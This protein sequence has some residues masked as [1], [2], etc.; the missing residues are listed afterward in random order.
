M[1]VIDS[2][3]TSSGD[4]SVPRYYSNLLSV[5]DHD[6]YTHVKAMRVE[7]SL[8]AHRNDARDFDFRLK[9]YK[10]LVNRLNVKAAVKAAS[11]RV[12]KRTL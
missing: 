3:V 7:R 9:S 10:R 5:I 11:I 2:C 4:Y 12:L 6:L 8:L 1:F